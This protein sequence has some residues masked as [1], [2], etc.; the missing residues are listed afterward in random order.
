MSIKYQHSEETKRK[1]KESRAK[2]Y[3]EHPEKLQARR[4]QMTK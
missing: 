3:K 2:F 1:R 4:D